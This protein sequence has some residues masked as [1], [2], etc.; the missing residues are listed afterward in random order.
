MRGDEV[1]SKTVMKERERK[2]DGGGVELR[3]RP[4]GGNERKS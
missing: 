1:R 3:R 2:E 4:G